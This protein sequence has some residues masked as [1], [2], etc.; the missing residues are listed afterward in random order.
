MSDGETEVAV[1]PGEPFSGSLQL[2]DSL[3][4]AAP[5]ASTIV[6]DHLPS[7]GGIDTAIMDEGSGCSLRHCLIGQRIYTLM[8][9]S[10][11]HRLSSLSLS[12]A[13]NGSRLLRATVTGIGWSINTTLPIR[14]TGCTPGYG[15]AATII[16]DADALAESRRVCSMCSPGTFQP[17]TALVQ[18]EECPAGTFSLSHG[19]AICESCPAGY[20]TNGL[21]GASQC[22]PCSSGSS[23]DGEGWCLCMQPMPYRQV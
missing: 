16:A 3:G 20:S 13:V 2:F 1:G 14:L 8:G 7:E 6:F 11:T 21:M 5:A 12:G 15:E 23:T 4:N 17:L 9:N 10:S 18:C 19:A 22:V